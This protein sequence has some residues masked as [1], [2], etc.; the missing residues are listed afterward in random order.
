VTT[1]EYVSVLLSIVVSL[2]FAHMLA[3]LARIIQA[4][5]AKLSWVYI[6]WMGLLI[7]TCVDYWFSLW[8]ARTT[9]NWSLGYVSFWLL[10]ATILYLTTWLAV[11]PEN[12]TT[13][14]VDLDAFYDANRRNIL[15]AFGAYHAI[16]LFGNLSVA[17]LQSAAIVSIVL[18]ALIGAAWMWRDRRVQIFAVSATYVLVAWYALTFVSA[19]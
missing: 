12:A 19:L 4:K 5:V 7:F 1:F 17:T 8:H 14:A 13:Q 2:A 6:A 16:G 18:V 11:P 3:G 15:G 9:D 10:L